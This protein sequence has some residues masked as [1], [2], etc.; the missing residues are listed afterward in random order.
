[1]DD[2]HIFVEL[3]PLPVLFV[4]EEEDLA[5]CFRQRVLAAMESIM[6]CLGDL[7]KIIA[8]R[9]YLPLCRDLQFVHEW[10]QPVQHLRDT[11]TD[12]GGVHH[13]QGFPAYSLGEEFQLVN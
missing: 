9:D 12:G 10:D 3:H 4:V 6:E 5:R 13:L 8:T 11:A 2:H 7:E 1:M